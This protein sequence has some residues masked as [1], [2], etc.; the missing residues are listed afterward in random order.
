MGFTRARLLI[1]GLFFLFAFQHSFAI[2]DS[3]GVKTVERKKYIVYKV[4]P[5]EGWFGIAKKYNL[6]TEEL[7]NANPKASKNLK[8]GEEILIPVVQTPIVSAVKETQ[9]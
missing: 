8:K 6:K 3:T 5:K 7:Q 4:E 9:P 2:P 1:A